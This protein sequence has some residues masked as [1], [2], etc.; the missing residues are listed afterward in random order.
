MQLI[1]RVAGYTVWNLKQSKD[2]C[3]VQLK[4]DFFVSLFLC[5]WSRWKANSFFFLLEN[6]LKLPL[7]LILYS[8]NI[9][10]G[11]PSN[12]ARGTKW[13][14]LVTEVAVSSLMLWSISMFPILHR[15]NSPLMGISNT[16]AVSLLSPATAKLLKLITLP[17]FCVSILIH[18]YFYTINIKFF[19]MHWSAL[20]PRSANP[21]FVLLAVYGYVLYTQN[22]I[23]S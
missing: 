23:P 8:A 5:V 7:Q 3:S 20:L 13:Q 11:M 2:F 16:C 19:H 4:T 17:N 14:L 9:L 12:A 22:P 15:C 1:Y 10:D 18:P 21:V 6:R